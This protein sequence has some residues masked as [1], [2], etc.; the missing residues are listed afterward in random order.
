VRS[1]VT[2]DWEDP[3]HRFNQG[4]W[5]AR[6]DKVDLVNL[7]NI[8]QNADLHH[9]RRAALNGALKHCTTMDDKSSVL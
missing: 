4:G 8:L 1:R 5:R 6:L 3:F 7:L 9:P 2:A